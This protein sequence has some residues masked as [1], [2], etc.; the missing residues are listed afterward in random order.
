MQQTTEIPQLHSID[1]VLDVP[2]VQVQL[3]TGAGCEKLVV[4]PQLHPYSCLDKVV[5]TPV[6]CNDRCLGFYC[7]ENCGVSA[8]A[9]RCLLAQFIDVVDV[10]VLM[11]RRVFQFLDKVFGMTVVSNDRCLGLT[12]PKQI[13]AS[14]ATDLGGRCP[15]CA[16]SSGSSF[17]QGR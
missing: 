12:V 8:V 14:R 10:P 11:Q 4:I 1:Q 5:R 15:C 2:V 3:F 13:V 17:G 6:V 7:A 9:R 16:G